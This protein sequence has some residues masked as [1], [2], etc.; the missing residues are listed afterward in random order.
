[1]KSERL[2]SP[3]LDMIDGLHRSG[4]S[5]VSQLV[6]VRAKRTWGR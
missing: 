3:W 4:A 2:R 5:V 6:E 1:M